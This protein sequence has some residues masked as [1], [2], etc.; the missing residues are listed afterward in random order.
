VPN[1]ARPARVGVVQNN[2]F[3]FGGNNAILMLGRMPAGDLLAPAG[4]GAAG[5]TGTGPA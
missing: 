1:V 5:S 2:G 4:P 3:G